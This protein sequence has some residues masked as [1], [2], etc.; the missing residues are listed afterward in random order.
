MSHSIYA[1]YF[2]VNDRPYCVWDWEL[3]KTN[4]EFIRGIDYRYF[5]YVAAANEEHLG[6]DDK[7]RAAIALRTAYHHGIE[8][9]LTLLGATLQAHACVFGW[10]LRCH[11]EDL[12]EVVQ[13]ISKGNAT[14]FNR[15]GLDQVSWR[16]VADVI[17]RHLN[18]GPELK[19]NLAKRFGDFWALAASDFLSVDNCNEYNSLKHGFRNK[20]GGF[21]LSVGQEASP[22]VAA[23][24]EGM[25]MLGGSEFGSSFLVPYGVDDRPSPRRE[26]VFIVRR[27]SLNW[28]PESLVNRL[29][30]LALSIEN[31]VAALRVLNGDSA[32]G[33]Q[34]RYP[35]NEEIFDELSGY[36]PGVLSMSFHVA[37]REKHI[38][39]PS[40]A[41]ILNSLRVIPACRHVPA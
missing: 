19:S 36:S 5:A 21:H 24:Q 23:P 29:V 16:S 13:Q 1:S 39:R 40:K 17:F 32:T 27:Q 22:G 35:T 3:Q 20:S 12:Q 14:L 28:S 26:H 37:I 31:V 30:L 9:L 8:T 7:H 33:V 25:T 34:F 18:A 38:A 4:I 10:I 2:I 6:G 41:D 11:T 15:H